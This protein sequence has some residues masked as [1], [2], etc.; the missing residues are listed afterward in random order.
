MQ[1][2]DDDFETPLPNKREH[3]PAYFMKSPFVNEFGSSGVVKEKNDI[4][5]LKNIHPFSKDIGEAL[6]FESL[7]AFDGW[8]EAGL[9]KK[10]KYV[11]IF[12][13]LVYLVIYK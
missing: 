3:R 1:V 5:I 13:L 2:D 7:S 8:I 11:L 10:N 9:K 12:C 6:E 4:S